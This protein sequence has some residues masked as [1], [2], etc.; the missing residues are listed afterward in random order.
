MNVENKNIVITGGC[1][2]I[3]EE[4][5]KQFLAKG[6]KIVIGDI[7]SKI[8]KINNKKSKNCIGFFCDATYEKNIIKL[9]KEAEKFFGPIDMFISNA[10]IMKGEKK[11]S[12]SANNK[13]WQL[14]WDLHVMSHVYAARATLPSMIER[15]R[16]YFLQ[17]VSAAALL[18]QVG[19]AA[20]SASKSAA[21]SFAE[22]L[23]ISH[24][25]EGIKVSVVCSQYVKTKMISN[26]IRLKDKEKIK[27]TKEIVKSIINGIE[28]EKFFIITDDKIEQ[29]MNYKIN[30]YDNWLT[31]MI[32]LRRK[33][34]TD[35]KTINVKEFYK[36]L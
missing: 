18:T 21:L 2:G 35:S 19:D 28:A 10:G 29:Y 17:I 23:A 36:F 14:Y 1:N 26:K 33:A 22:S 20:Y 5:V 34:L 3:G 30:N 24:A 15:K 32:N 16:G 11:S 6:A 4:I 31:K 12:T 7:S 9:V 8:N 27:S 13:L 25:D